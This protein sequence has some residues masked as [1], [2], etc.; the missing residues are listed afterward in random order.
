MS[1]TAICAWILR[2]FV[3]AVGDVGAERVDRLELGD[4]VGPLV[5]DLGEHLL[6]DVFHDHAELHR[7]LVGILGLRVER[8]DVAD[9]RATKVVVELVG[10]EPVPTS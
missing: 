5:G 7:R 1:R 4:V 2:T 8:Q 10:N 3:I 9:L 6:L